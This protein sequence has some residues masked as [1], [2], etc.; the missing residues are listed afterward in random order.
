MKLD[1]DPIEWR[2]GTAKLQ[3]PGSDIRILTTQVSIR[4]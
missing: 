4:A 3:L 2:V 1:Q